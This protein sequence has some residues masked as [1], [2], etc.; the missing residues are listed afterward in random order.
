MYKTPL[1]DNHVRRGA[2]LIDFGGWR[3]PLHFTSLL[4]EHH[5]ARRDAG[6]FDV[7]HMAIT[8]L[9]GRDVRIFLQ[10][11]LANDAG[12]LEQP[13]TALYSC[14]LR[15]DGGILDDLI[16]Y[17]LAPDLYRIVSNAATRAKDLAWIGARAA[18]HELEL[19]ERTDLGLLALQ[20]PGALH[21]LEASLPDLAVQGQ[22]LAAFQC[23]EA[24]GVFIARTGYTGED[25]F[26]ISLPAAGI[27]AVW[28][29]LLA[30]GA[31][32]CG[33]GARDTLRL[34]AGLNLYGQDMDEEITPW[35][36]GLAWTVALGDSREFVGRT[37]LEGQR[38]S[39]V[40]R[41][42]VGLALE[43]PGVMRVGYPLTTSRGAGMITSG[44]FSPTLARSIALARVP[45]GAQ[46][47]A[48]V[49]VR[50][51]ARRALIVRPPFVKNGRSTL[52][53]ELG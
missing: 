27:E 39:G 47:W 3:M 4:A 42:R 53:P 9:S 14:M 28:D 8:D 49:S 48:E 45:A 31:T 11:L 32:P 19:A 33:L 37:A 35:E 26:E 43:G 40:T 10:G 41:Q 7:S 22:A 29:G 23:V 15:D 13:G 34:E 38:A 6:L 17:R 25:G 20:G 1:H 21:V 18:G 5:A 36:C 30:S 50:G 52:P 44:S 51:Q 16:V 2:K 46:G 24:N 12:K